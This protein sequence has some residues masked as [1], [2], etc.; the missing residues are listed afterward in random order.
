M[1]LNKGKKEQT[2]KTSGPTY[3]VQHTG[4]DLIT[5]MGHFVV[6]V[7][8]AC[9]VTFYVYWFPLATH[10]R[11]FLKNGY[12]HH[13]YFHN[14]FGARLIFST[15]QPADKLKHLFWM[16][17]NHCENM[18]FVI[19]FLTFSLFSNTCLSSS[20]Y[21]IRKHSTEHLTATNPGNSAR[22]SATCSLAS[23]RESSTSNPGAGPYR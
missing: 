10:F 3:K 9:V 23:S 4:T 17:W 13:T 18:C 12:S 8:C 7:C 22:T 6:S 15:L 2:P 11:F 1:K 20:F 21:H 19:R 14:L 5:L 16:W